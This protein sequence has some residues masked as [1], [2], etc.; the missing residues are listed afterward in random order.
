MVKGKKRDD[1]VI[2]KNFS[3]VKNAA[4]L[5]EGYPGWLREE[6]KLGE[7]SRNVL[8]CLYFMLLL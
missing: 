5:V 2:E 8:G 3:Y 6:R 4:V 1:Y 7:Q